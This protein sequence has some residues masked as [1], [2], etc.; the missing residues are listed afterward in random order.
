MFPKSSIADNLFTTTFCFAIF[1]LPSDKAKVT[2]A[3]K[4][5]G[6]MLTIKATENKKVLKYSLNPFNTI[7]A[8]KI[9][10]IVTTTIL[11]INLQKYKMLFS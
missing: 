4:A 7:F 9:K 11:K 6:K 8:I 5:S 2:T 3:G 10:I 1:K